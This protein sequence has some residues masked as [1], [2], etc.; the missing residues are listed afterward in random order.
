MTYLLL[1]T[2]CDAWFCEGDCICKTVDF[3]FI[4]ILS[5]IVSCCVEIPT[6]KLYI[7]KQTTMK[8]YRVN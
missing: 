2:E 8:L 4:N 3:C 7:C 1:I 6:G 5:M